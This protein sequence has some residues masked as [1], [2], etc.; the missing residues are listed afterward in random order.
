MYCV[1]GLAGIFDGLISVFFGFF[2]SRPRLS[3]L[4]MAFSSPPL[5]ALSHSLCRFFHAML[6]PV[7]IEWDRQ[8]A[9]LQSVKSKHSSNQRPYEKVES[10]MLLVFA[11]LSSCCEMTGRESEKIQRQGSTHDRR[12][13]INPGPA[14][15]TTARI[16]KRTLRTRIN[17]GLMKSIQVGSS[18]Y[19]AQN[20]IRIES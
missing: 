14:S 8:T 13:A 10:E 5:Q 17:A 6:L 20:R 15:S 3:R 7:G 16:S 12:P 1:A 18:V 2:F 11:A 19:I 9:I 4:P